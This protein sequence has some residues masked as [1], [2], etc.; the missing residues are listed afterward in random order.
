MDTVYD[1]FKSKPNVAYS[2]TTVAKRLNM[3]RGHIHRILASEE[4]T[5][6]K[7]VVPGYVGSGK[8]MVNVFMYHDTN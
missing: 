2:V 4:N 8:K 5:H 3:K 6:I 1:F 7:R